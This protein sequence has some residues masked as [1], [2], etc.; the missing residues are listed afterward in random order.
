MSK[1]CSVTFLYEEIASNQD[2]QI[3]GTLF[4]GK[5]GLQAFKMSADINVSNNF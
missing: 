5:T 3:I 1:N 2:L 4:N